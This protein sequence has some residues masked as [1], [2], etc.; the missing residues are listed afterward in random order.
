VSLEAGSLDNCGVPEQYRDIVI[1]GRVMVAKSDRGGSWTLGMSALKADGTGRL[2]GTTAYGGH[3]F[4]FD[5]DVG[6]GPRAIRARSVQAP[7]VW[8]WTPA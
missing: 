7:C 6:R 1:K 3:T 2:T 8:L 5:F 4:Y